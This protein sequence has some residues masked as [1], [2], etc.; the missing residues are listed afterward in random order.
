MESW[1]NQ[2]RWTER[3]SDSWF[4]FFVYGCE[5]GWQFI[6]LIV[7]GG[8]SPI[9]FHH[10]LGLFISFS[11]D[12][13]RRLSWTCTASNIVSNEYWKQIE[14]SNFCIQFDVHFKRADHDDA[15]PDDPHLF[16]FFGKLWANTKGPPGW[17][18]VVVVVVIVEWKTSHKTR[19]NSR[20]SLVR[21]IGT[22]VFFSKWVWRILNA[23]YHKTGRAE[24]LNVEHFICLLQ[25]PEK[26][27]SSVNMRCRFWAQNSMGSRAASLSLYVFV[28][29]CDLSGHGA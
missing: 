14:N 22:K 1:F 25:C 20:C 27:T 8:N 29:E 6:C 28:S 13:I 3:T 16:F 5:F 12:C 17:P 26:K 24:K 18:A 11:S 21:S 23:H 10:I 7:L 15:D 4:F 9:L 19:S 2:I